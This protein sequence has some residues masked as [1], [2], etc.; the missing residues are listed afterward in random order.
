MGGASAGRSVPTAINSRKPM[1]KAGAS[2]VQ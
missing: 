2:F 1:K